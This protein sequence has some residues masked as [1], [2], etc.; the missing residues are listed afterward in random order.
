[1]DR[2]WET[3]ISCPHMCL[4]QGRTHHPDLCPDQ[5]SN[6]RPFTLQ[7]NAHP[8]S[9]AG[10][11][12]GL[13]FLTYF[14]LC[15][16]DCHSNWHRSVRVWRKPLPTVYGTTRRSSR[17]ERPATVTDT[18]PRTALAVGL[19]PSHAERPADKRVP[20][21]ADTLW[22]AVKQRMWCRKKTVTGTRTLTYKRWHHCHSISDY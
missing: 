22:G 19:G 18:S 16:S 12:Y 3:S 1:M 13:D 17:R 15:L 6:Q 7:D 11:D 21:R 8:L 14:I 5:A 10:R 20:S 9:H 4:N 2:G